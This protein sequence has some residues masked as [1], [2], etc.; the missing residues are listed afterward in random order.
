MYVNVY[1]T[2]ADPPGWHTGKTS[3]VNSG[4]STVVFISS[5]MV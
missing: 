1:V 4:V 3:T 2:L 5:D